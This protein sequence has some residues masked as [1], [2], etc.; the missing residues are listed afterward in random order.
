MIVVIAR[1]LLPAGI[2]RIMPDGKGM[3]GLMPWTTI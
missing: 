2:C 3:G 1:L